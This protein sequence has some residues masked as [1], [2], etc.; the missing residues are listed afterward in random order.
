MTIEVVQRFADCRAALA[1]Y[2]DNY[3]DALVTDPPAGISFMGKEWDSGK[4]FI[5]FLTEVFTLAYA[6]MKPGAHGLIWALPRTSHW[7]ATALENA[8]FEIRDEV[9]HIF[10][11]GFPKNYDAAKGV[12]SKLT[13]GSANWNGFRNLP[14]QVVKGEGEGASGLVKIN[15]EQGNRPR[16]YSPGQRVIL[17]PTT[18]L[19]QRYMGYGTALKPAKENWILIKK[20][21]KG[22][23][24]ACI[25]QYGTGAINI[26]ACRVGTGTGEI[27]TVK[28]NDIRGNNYGRSEGREIEVERKDAGRWPPNLVFSHDVECGPLACAPGCPV[29]ELDEQSGQTE[30]KVTKPGAANI[31]NMAGLAGKKAAKTG[32][33]AERGHNDSGGASRFFPVFEFDDDDKLA[34]FGYFSKPTKSEKN[35]GLDELADRVKVFNGQSA[36]PSKIIAAGSVEDK[37]STA[38]AKNHH[39]TVKATALMKWLISLITPP[40]PPDGPPPLVVDL[41]AGSGSG[42]VAAVQVGGVRW[43]GF[44]LDESYC[45]IAQRRIAFAQLPT[46]VQKR[47]RGQF[48][49]DWS[50][51]SD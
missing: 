23:V 13:T 21:H 40:A 9:T 3:I 32:K 1:E 37:F 42:G 28:T 22:S 5:E 43:H 7:T 41:F 44:D 18:E 16:Q 49:I 39:P 26:D 8:G 15:H 30:S 50:L 48:Y 25:I 45:E 38:P 14:G 47:K 51:Y 12:E 36:E 29:A 6:K 31:G 24:A 10:G 20:P 34:I 35:A 4:G 27:K 33:R 19:A 46:E 17:E 2:E 11:N